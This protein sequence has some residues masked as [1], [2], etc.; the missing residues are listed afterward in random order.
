MGFLFL[1]RRRE[2]P[3]LGWMGVRVVVGGEGGVE[4]GEEV[5][6]HGAF[7]PRGTELYVGG[8]S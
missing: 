6:E 2:E 5:A 8:P 7:G 3:G 1:G 4:P